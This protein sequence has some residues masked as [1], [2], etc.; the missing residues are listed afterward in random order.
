MTNRPGRALAVLAVL[1]VL[2]CAA[3]GAQP[4]PAPPAP[5]AAPGASGP[6]FSARQVCDPDDG[7]KDIAEALSLTPTT[8]TAPTWSDHL[9]S[10]RYVYPDGSFTL[11]VKELTNDPDAVAYINQLAARL[12]EKEQLDGVGQGAFWTTNGSLVT[13]KDNKILLVDVSKLPARF[14]NPP[15]PPAAISRIVGT[16]IMGCW[17]GD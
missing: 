15:Q 14:S 17:N 1:A 13:R 9:Y 5:P 12:G 16:V 8:V 7:Q 6:S 11:S 2:V 4:A 3:C 10:C